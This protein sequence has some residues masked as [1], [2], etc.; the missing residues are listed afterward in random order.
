MVTCNRCDSEMVNDIQVGL[1][2][3]SPNRFV[4][5]E[6]QSCY[7]VMYFIFTCQYHICNMYKGDEGA[8]H[9]GAP[10]GR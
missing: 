6:Y 8:S 7:H 3:S 4:N 9:Q 5:Q 2:F 1:I 10:N